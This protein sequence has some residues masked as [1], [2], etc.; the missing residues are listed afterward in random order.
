MR[1]PFPVIVS[2]GRI[3]LEVRSCG[4][5]FLG[6]QV[7]PERTWSITFLR[8][9]SEE[10]SLAIIARPIRSIP[11]AECNVQRRLL[12]SSASFLVFLLRMLLKWLGMFS[13]VIHLI[14][15]PFPV[16]NL[17]WYILVWASAKP[18]QQIDIFELVEQFVRMRQGLCCVCLYKISDRKK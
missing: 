3:Y 6:I 14:Q 17:V 13:D 7:C 12:S 8:V 4:L 2:S 10:I 11:G 15:L 5:S 18:D 9:G 1:M 16:L